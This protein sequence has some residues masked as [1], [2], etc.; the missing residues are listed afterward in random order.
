MGSLLVFHFC[1]SLSFQVQFSSLPPH[2][3]PNPPVPAKSVS[4]LPLE[5]YPP[6]P[7]A[8]EPPS[9]LPEA[10]AA[11]N[12]PFFQG[13][14]SLIH[15]LQG[16]QTDP[17]PAHHQLPLLMTPP[18]HA[19]RPPTLHS[20]PPTHV[21][22]PPTPPHASPL[23]SPGFQPWPLGG[24]FCLLISP[25]LGHFADNWISLHFLPL[26]RLPPAGISSRSTSPQQVSQDPAVCSQHQGPLAALIIQAVL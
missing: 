3:P 15:P 16:S 6:L 5:R 10:S 8:S 7:W 12:W 19:H 9:S 1:K 22:P 2:C 14:C 4:H 23:P 26:E 20:P 17:H 11:S 25:G 24:S 13:S 18:P 21:H